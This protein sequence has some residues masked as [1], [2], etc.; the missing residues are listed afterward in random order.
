MNPLAPARQERRWVCVQPSDSYQAN[1]LNRL[2]ERVA[3]TT[4]A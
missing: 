4:L 3:A 1:V 2:T